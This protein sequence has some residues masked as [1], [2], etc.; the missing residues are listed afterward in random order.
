MNTNEFQISACLQISSALRNNA[1]TH[2]LT[3]VLGTNKYMPP[4]AFCDSPT[5]DASLDILSLG[6]LIFQMI[7]G[8]SPDPGDRNK[9]IFIS[10]RKSKSG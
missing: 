10:P 6:I 4:E 7:T 9:V 1:L 2:T 3:S 5:Y 8:L